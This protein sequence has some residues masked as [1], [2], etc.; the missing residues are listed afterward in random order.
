MRTVALMNAWGGRFRH[1]V[2][3]MTGNYEARERVQSH[4]RI[5][6]HETDRRGYA[7]VREI[8]DAAATL[9]PDLMLTYNWG[10]IDSTILNAIRRPCP[11]IHIEDGFGPDEAVQ[12]KAR[13]VLTRRFILPLI[14]ATVVPSQTL[15]QIA[16]Q[17]YKLREPKVRF[18]PNGIDMDRFR[19]RDR[20]SWRRQVGISCETLVLGTVGRLRAEKNLGLLLRAY[21]AAELPDSRLAIA[22]DGEALPELRA[23]A[24]ELKISDQVLF[25]GDL[26]DP[27]LFLSDLDLFVMSSSTEQMPM[28]LLEAMAS[29][30]PA[31]CTAVGDTAFMLGTEA[32]PACVPRGN[33]E[34][35]TGALKQMAGEPE[36]RRS[37][38]DQNLARCRELFTFQRMLDSHQQLYLEAIRSHKR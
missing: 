17:Q 4:V 34:A 11:V 20:G 29:G 22:G 33:P 8:S 14:Y 38:G 27:S 13:R 23:L 12:L 36:L 7:R 24:S 35:F 2:F 15:L 1:T 31:V 25:L 21:A 3:S 28:A 19:P 30:L 32:A 18:I 26:P 16:H 6:C 10:A 9:H 37:L 5:T